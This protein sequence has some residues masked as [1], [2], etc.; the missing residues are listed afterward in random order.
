[1]GGDA[2]GTFNIS[3]VAAIIAA[4][5]GVPVVKH[6]NRGVSSRCGSADLLEELGIPLEMEPTRMRECVE[7][8][9]IGF[10]YAPLY[11]GAMRHAAG[12]RREVGIRTVFNLLGPLANPAGARAQLLG[13]YDP[14]LTHTIAEVLAEL[15]TDRAMVVHGEGLDE[16]TTTGK[17]VISELN[18]GEIFDYTM[19]CTSFGIPRANRSDL[20]GGAPAE[21]ARILRNILSGEEGP[22]RDISVL[23]AGAAI[24]IG[25]HAGDLDQG[26]RLAKEA[27]DS[28][29]AQRKL[30]ELVGFFTGGR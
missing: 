20:A 5:A 19:D 3:T 16:I 25:G 13:V 29:R 17:S 15:G 7:K 18:G 4:A 1:T 2:S 21:N 12:P 23:N 30:E 9:G 8:C 24:Y 10:F 28:G 6:G 27:I 11:H 26:V 22:R 14:D